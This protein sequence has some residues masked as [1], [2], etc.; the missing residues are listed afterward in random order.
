MQRIPGH[1]TD[2]SAGT[3]SATAIAALSDGSTY[4]NDVAA[5]RN[6]LATIAA[7]LNSLIDLTKALARRVGEL[8]GQ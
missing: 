5:I 6:N 3:A 7:T 4:A 2:N 8:E 1:L